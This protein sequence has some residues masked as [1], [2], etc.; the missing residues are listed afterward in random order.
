MSK[1]LSGI[2]PELVEKKLE[3]MQGYIKE[4]EEVREISFEDYLN[5]HFKRR[6]IERLIQC[7]VECATD[8]NSYLVSKMAKIAPADYFDSFL[9]AG[10]YNILPKEFSVQIAPSAGL[11]NRLVHEYDKIDDR[12]VH[13]SIKATLDQYSCY[14]KYVYDFIEALKS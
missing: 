11:R 3:S 5:D 14:I 1:D 9:K 4:L 8:I 7:I 6:G 12:I 13:Q 2:D 10:E